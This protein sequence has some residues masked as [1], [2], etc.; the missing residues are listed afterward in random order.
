MTKKI[1]CASLRALALI[2]FASMISF[3]ICG[4]QASNDAKLEDELLRYK[5]AYKAVP[6][7]VTISPRTDE[8]GSTAWI[9]PWTPDLF[10]GKHPVEIVA[11]SPE[12]GERVTK[13]IS[14]AE[15]LKDVRVK[16]SSSPQAINGVSFFDPE[17]RTKPLLIGINSLFADE[18]LLPENGCEIK[19]YEGYD[20][21]IFGKDEAL[22]LVPADMADDFDNGN[23]ETAVYFNVTVGRMENGTFVETSR[24]EHECTLKIVGTYTAGDGKSIYCS[25]PI[26]EKV[27]ESM[28]DSVSIDA[29]S[30]T[31]ADNMRLDEFRETASV[32]FPKLAENP[33]EVPKIVKVN[34]RSNS[35]TFSSELNSISIDDDDLFD[36]TAPVLEKEAELN[37]MLE[38]T[39]LVASVAAGL[40]VGLIVTLLRKRGIGLKWEKGSSGAAIVLGALLEQMICTIVGIAAGG[41]YYSW[42]PVDKL[43]TFAVVY[44]A[45]LTFVTVTVMS[46]ILIKLSKSMNRDRSYGG[47]NFVTVC[48]K[49]I[50]STLKRLK[51]TPV[52]AVAL[53]LFASIVTLI[54]CGLQASS[55]AEMRRFEKSCEEVAITV[56]VSN[57]S[58]KDT[59]TVVVSEDKVIEIPDPLFVTDWVYELFTGKVPVSFYDVSG[60]DDPT[61]NRDELN[62]LMSESMPVRLSLTEYL[63]DIKVK[64]SISIERINGGEFNEP[65]LIGMT[66]LSCEP[67]LLPENGCDL[68]WREGYDES[69]F[70]SEDAVC[71]VPS[72]KAEQYDN[73]NGEV[74]LTFTNKVLKSV[75]VDGEF[76]VEYETVEYEYTFKIAGTYT[77]G[78]WNSV[79]CSMGNANRITEESGLYLMIGALSGNIAD[80]SRLEEFREK[81]SFCFLEPGPASIEVPWD[82][83]VDHSYYEFYPYA[84]KIES[85][86]MDALALALEE[87]IESNRRASLVVLVIFAVAGAVL[88]VAMNRSRKREILLMRTLGEPLPRVFFGLILEQIICI[89]LGMIISGAAFLWKPIDKLLIY[90]LIYFVCLVLASL[91]IMSKKLIRTVKEVK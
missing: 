89:L 35:Y 60:I 22:C 18:A 52:R 48:K 61:K 13:Q 68:L 24:R 12:N 71:L 21:S 7:T 46:I 81:A 44:F 8:K 15:Y 51:R 38:Q 30:A 33:G 69:I 54:L 63:K 36:Y 64:G 16:M 49:I 43:F 55:D 10:T 39:V 3:A 2:L 58:G 56:S 83:Y 76:V 37:S 45:V 17:T 20:E 62:K 88:S 28:E 42:K 25:L 79:Y 57:P 27:R 19:W 77:G 87:K 82:Y 47:D 4:L 70:D 72:G 31:I 80:Y 66:S 53:M 40:L 50:F 73:G 5:E 41:A 90:A 34:H 1:I 65:N 78:D 11:V 67:E 91:V 26:I 14:F 75:S 32:F 9:N 86:E 85:A 74:V 23:G 59:E 84:L 6:V 29:V